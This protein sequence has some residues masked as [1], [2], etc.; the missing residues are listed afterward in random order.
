MAIYAIDTPDRPQVG[1][2]TA[3]RGYGDMARDHMCRVNELTTAEADRTIDAASRE[4]RERSLRDWRIAFAPD[5]LARY[6]E[7]SVLTRAFE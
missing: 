5:L 1:V 6:P 2:R 4:W 7:L 3:V